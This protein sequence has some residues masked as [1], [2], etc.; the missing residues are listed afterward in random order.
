[1][2]RKV[3][4]LALALVLGSSAIHAQ[5]VGFVGQWAP[6]FA[7]GFEQY[8][9]RNGLFSTV[10]SANGLTLTSQIANNGDS[11]FSSFFLQN[12]GYLRLPPVLLPQG[13]VSYDYRIT[14]FSALGKIETFDDFGNTRVVASGD[15][16]SGTY[17][18]LYQ[19]GYFGYFGVNIRGTDGDMAYGDANATVELTNLLAPV[20]EP[21]S[22]L[23]VGGGL[24]G[25]FAL[26]RRQR[27]VA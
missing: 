11:N 23:L 4:A 19:G 27:G 6:T 17:S 3:S 8:T 20:P 13:N 22:L 10:V 25:L 26:R 2:T 21:G 12:Y 16:I 9:E 5:T 7:N 15:V 1:M 24:V 18:Q 14:Y